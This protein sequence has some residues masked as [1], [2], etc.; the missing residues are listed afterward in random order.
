M[1]SMD[2]S[3]SICGFIESVQ[4]GDAASAAHFLSEEFGVHDGLDRYA[5]ADH[6][7]REFGRRRPWL[8]LPLK[9]NILDRADT[10]YHIA[11]ED[12][13]GHF[14]YEDLLHVD[15]QGRLVGNGDLVEMVPKLHFH[16]DG[17]ASRGM[18]L[19]VRDGKLSRVHVVAPT[20]SHYRFDTRS[21]SQEADEA[22]H[23]SFVIDDDDLL[24]KD[25]E[26]RFYIE[27]GKGL[28]A[29]GQSC[30]LRGT[31]HP[32]FI[33]DLHPVIR[34]TRVSFS[35]HMTNAWA[36]TVELDSGRF[37]TIEAP[38]RD[39]LEFE[40]PV[41]NVILTDALDNDWDGI[42]AG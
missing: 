21:S 1:S 42:H 2:A 14:V 28:T 19:R 8:R 17:T 39:D 40:E 27:T 33:C 23:L 5:Y 32:Y 38:S 20:A 16:A 11:I 12:A 34:G 18:S 6:E 37:V 24:G 7:I 36:V 13:L 35:R 3:D 41:R 25:G 15:G 30:R 22:S 4:A 10:C 26:F 9:V 29:C 31:D